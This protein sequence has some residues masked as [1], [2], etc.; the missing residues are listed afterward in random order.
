MTA[1]SGANILGYLLTDIL[2]VNNDPRKSS[3]FDRLGHGIEDAVYFLHLRSQLLNEFFDRLYVPQIKRSFRRVL[4]YMSLL[5]CIEMMDIFSRL[6]V[7]GNKIGGVSVYAGFFGIA[8]VTL[9]TL[10]QLSA[11]AYCLLSIGLVTAVGIDILVRFGC[12]S[13]TL[14]IQSPVVILLTFTAYTHLP[15][16]IS[17]S[18]AFHLLLYVGLSTIDSFK[19]HDKK[20]YLKVP[21]DAEVLEDTS[22]KSTVALICFFLMLVTTSLAIYV[23]TFVSLRFR[24]SFLRVCQAV[25]ANAKQREALGQQVMWFDAVM[26]KRIR[27]KYWEV[28]KQHKDIDRSLWVFCDT[29]DPTSIMFVDTVGLSDL[30]EKLS[31]DALMQLL[32]ALFSGF[33]ALCKN[34]GCEKVGTM[35]SIYYCVSGCPTTRS[36]HAICCANAALAMLESMPS[37]NSAHRV[38]LSLSIGI[39]TG[40]LNG[41]LVGMDRFRFDIYSYSVRTAQ[42]LL[43]TCPPGKIH[44]SEAVQQLLPR[45][46][47]TSEAA[48]IIEKKEVQ[49]AIAGMKLE[50]VP[51]N[52]YYLDLKSER[53]I[54][55]SQ[56][57]PRY[58]ERSTFRL[59]LKV[60]LG[61]EAADSEAEPGDSEFND[62]KVTKTHSSELRKQF[63]QTSSHLLPE[64]ANLRETP[65]GRYERPSMQK[66]WNKDTSEED[67]PSCIRQS[68]FGLAIAHRNAITQLKE[69]KE[70]SALDNNVIK[71]LRANPSHLASLFHA[72]P[73]HPISLHFL[74]KTLE[75]SYRSQER[76]EMK[77]G[78]VD[79]LKLAP[80]F[81]TTFLFFYNLI[82][83]GSFATAVSWELSLGIYLSLSSLSV[84]IFVMLPVCIWI[85]C[86]IF[87]NETDIAKP[88]LMLG[89]KR[90]FIEMFCF[91]FGQL[92]TTLIMVCLFL[93]PMSELFPRR[94]GF[95]LF[96]GPP[97]IFIHCIPMDSSFIVRSG[98]AA[99][100]TIIMI[101]LLVSYAFS[102]K[103]YL[104]RAEHAW[105]YD[106]G[107]IQPYTVC[108]I[109]TLIS[110]WVLVV[111][112]CRQNE[113][114][115]RM[116]FFMDLEARDANKMAS[117]TMTECNTLLYNII[118]RYVFT[119]LR[120][121]GRQTLDAK[122]VNHA[123]L[124][125]KAGIAFVR[126]TNFFEGYYREDYQGG[127]Q[128]IGLLN[129]II[130]TFDRL[131]W[132]RDFRDVEKIKTYNDSYMVAAGLNL[133]RRSSHSS[134]NHH[135]VKIIKFCLNLFKLIDKFNKN[136]VIGSENAFQLG[137]GVD[138][139]RVCTGLIGS[140][141]PY[142][143]VL[144]PPTEL[145]Y[146]LHL[147][148]PPQTLVT[149][150]AA[151]RELSLN[152]IFE[153]ITLPTGTK[154]HEMKKIYACRKK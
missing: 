72:Q 105:F 64:F 71:E 21:S 111:L 14:A 50:D 113:T 43:A 69:T 116:S 122:A 33:D 84:T 42:Q 68:I 103:P 120:A 70:M 27:T 53:L 25:Y 79:S 87:S 151:M 135:L 19:T 83:A 20:H 16:P 107:H 44:I 12:L 37:I 24:A 96:F 7:G 99:I 40:S 114:C 75:D 81:D 73:L 91:I 1:P 143:D 104:Q 89:R 34:C 10:N 67:R 129:Q 59:D 55:D 28:A 36:D 110:A 80:A 60:G 31:A 74:D 9:F 134:P 93:L 109:I 132:K 6:P 3:F 52:T 26:P 136:F 66:V 144:G 11:R 154:G 22:R 17:F 153:E 125:E 95:V 41:A 45:S 148:A 23:R 146:Q 13:V 145:A 90:V 4:I 98:S 147:A 149:S 54:D 94:D 15:V 152:F 121:K 32:N 100:S 108:S 117:K 2:N 57:A 78:Y 112:V 46:F 56:H 77:P 137:I 49:S 123:M 106:V 115:C 58:R 63:S 51:M 85:N 86:A 76:S 141:K 130:C 88:F 5:L 142:Y 8:L 18:V 62:R 119:S 97:A 131:L 30:A 48:S 92:P 128:A 127:K 39:H 65:Y 126:L 47:I 102:Q 138:V 38:G 150:E 101:G 35:G 82:F 133:E 118:P 139:G 61:V 140:V 124:V 29:Y